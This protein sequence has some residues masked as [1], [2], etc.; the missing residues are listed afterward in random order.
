MKTFHPANSTLT[1]Y[2]RSSMSDRS[3]CNFSGTGILTEVLCKSILKA[4][5][6]HCLHKEASMGPIYMF[7]YKTGFPNQCSANK[8]TCDSSVGPLWYCL[9]LW[10]VILITLS[11][12]HAFSDKQETNNCR[13]WKLPYI[14]S[15]GTHLPFQLCHPITFNH[16][17]SISF[18]FLIFFPAISLEVNLNGWVVLPLQLLSTSWRAGHPLKK[19]DCCS[20]QR[21]FS[22]QLSIFYGLLTSTDPLT[23]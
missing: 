18:P 6:K 12:G 14:S 3:Q 8:S 1:R 17:I 9:C 7:T 22:D 11:A 13:P 16:Y 21:N 5:A 23:R 15:T 20:R 10:P 19:W 2:W 4:E